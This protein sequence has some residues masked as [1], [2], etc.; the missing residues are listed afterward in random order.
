MIHH[1]LQRLKSP[2]SVL[3]F[4]FF[5][6]TSFSG[7]AIATTYT[8]YIHGKASNGGTF[9]EGAN[10][11]DL[12]YWAPVDGVSVGGFN[13]RAINWDGKNRIADTNAAIR[14]GLDCYCTGANNCHVV[15]HSAGNL[16]LGY[17]LEK[18]GSSKRNKFTPPNYNGGAPASACLNAYDLAAS[19]NKIFGFPP[20]ILAD[21]QQ[22][23]WNIK[24]VTVAAGAAGGSELARPITY[25][26][27]GLNRDLDV[28]TARSL[29]DHNKTQGH[30]FNLY[31]GA[32]S[33][34]S[35]L[36]TDVITDLATG[37]VAALLPGEDDGAVAYHSSAGRKS[38][39]KFCNTGVVWFNPATWGCTKV[40]TGKSDA[41]W[42]NH[43]VSNVDT[44]ESYNHNT[45]KKLVYQAAENFR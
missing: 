19:I 15:V 34:V 16:Q 6:L 7:T 14:D 24:S 8:V 42:T 2:S 28:A 22:S 32:N 17:A 39:G 38:S 27:A 9:T 40:A 37:A 21:F 35:K 4:M 10:Y 20:P 33:E 5:A 23:G 11:H 25:P 41:A 3:A 1:I 31:I 12:S 44:S 26:M 13:Q 43:S 18:Y 36:W 30:L 29:Y 45:V